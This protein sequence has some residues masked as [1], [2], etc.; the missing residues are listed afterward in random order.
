MQFDS[1]DL[2][3][4]EDSGLLEDVILHEMDHV[5]GFGTIWDELDL[6]TGAGSS[7]PR[8]IGEGATT[9][10]NDIFGVSESGV[11]VEAD[12]GPGTALS[13]W[14]EDVF[15]NELMTGFIN[16]GENP[17]SRVTAASMGDLGYEVNVDAADAYTPPGIGERSPETVGRIITMNTEDMEFVDPITPRT[18]IRI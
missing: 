14:D 11:P 6:L 17:L 10:Y 15:G 5:I 4:L 7:N 1:A 3:F 13:H 9:E 12:F 16:F 18:E 2:E 8:F